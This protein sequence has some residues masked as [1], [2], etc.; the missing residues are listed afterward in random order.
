MSNSVVRLVVLPA[1][2]FAAFSGAAFGLAKAHLAK[3][4]VSTS[5]PVELGDAYRGATVFSQQCESCHGQGGRGGG[6]GPALAGNPV[7]LAASKAQID[8][9]G[10][11]MPAGLVS[12]QQERDVLAYLATIRAPGTGGG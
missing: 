11:A 2:L 9:G 1:L 8:N 10:G 4:S 7:S 3:P 12:G 6:I 5:G